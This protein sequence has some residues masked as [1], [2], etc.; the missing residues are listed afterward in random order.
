MDCVICRYGELALK[1]KNRHIFEDR[2]VNN[3]HI[4]L[5]KHDISADTKKIRGRIFIFT[6]DE[7]A[8]SALKNI[9]GLVSISPAI[10]SEN[11][12]QIIEK[13]VIDYVDDIIQSK[14]INTFRI[15]TRRANKVFLK[16]SNEMDIFLGNAIGDRFKL[17]AQMKDPDINIGVEIHDKT[18]IFHEM[19]S[20]YGGLPLGSSG[21]VACLIEG[22]AGAAA[23]WLMMKRGC[24]IIVLTRKKI[25]ID[26]LTKFSYGLDIK[27]VMIDKFEE[28][29]QLMENNSYKALVVG[30][31]LEGFD[32]EKYKEIEKPVL[33]PIIAYT[34]EQVNDLIEKI[35]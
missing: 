26:N 5:A 8:L 24:K 25:N 32:P 18:F 7:K 9:F 20:C 15:S 10:V 27:P 14:K 11:L 17:K 33:T 2:L 34:E 16:S 1:G 3:I 23:A 22:D 21:T 29:N 31:T 19:I 28:L 4:C 6:S 30:D 35:R 12:P 13:T